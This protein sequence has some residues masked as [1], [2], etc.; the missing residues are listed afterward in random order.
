[1]GWYWQLLIRTREKKDSQNA[2]PIQVLV[3]LDTLCTTLPQP[4][5]RLSISHIFR[6]KF[7][8]ICSLV[9]PLLLLNKN[10]FFAR[11]LKVELSSM[12]HILVLKMDSGATFLRLLRKMRLTHSLL[13]AE[14]QGENC[15][16]PTCKLLYYHWIFCSTGN[17]ILLCQFQN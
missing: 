7:E 8:S 17:D 16:T 15:I 13:R 1:V 4:L 14:G 10:L 12:S 2:L 6:K 9:Q 11:K 3:K 5:L